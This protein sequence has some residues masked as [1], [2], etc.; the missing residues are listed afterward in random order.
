MIVNK[1]YL[2][3]DNYKNQHDMKKKENYEN[4][5]LFI[6]FLLFKEHH[7]EYE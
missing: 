1:K 3:F 5:F 6:F 2:L 7:I 4:S